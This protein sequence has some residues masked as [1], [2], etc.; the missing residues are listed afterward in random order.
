M[1][2]HLIDAFNEVWDAR[3]F[4]RPDPLGYYVI[5]RDIFNV[6]RIS[7]MSVIERQKEKGYM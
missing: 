5:M 6:I 2:H 4:Y 1:K 3:L 7:K